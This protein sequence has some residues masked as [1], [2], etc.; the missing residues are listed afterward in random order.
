MAE[1]DP[2]QPKRD[3]ADAVAVVTGSSRGIGRGIAIALGERGATVYI[4][5]RTTGD[6]PLTIDSTAR[7]VD[8]A[9]GV[10]IAVQTDHTDDEQIA[11][12]F[13]R[14][15]EEQGRIDVLVNNVYKIPSPPVWGGGFWEHPYQVW[16]DQVGTGARCHYV[17]SWHAAPLL[18]EG[19]GKLIVNISSPGGLGYHYSSS[20]G[21]GKAALDRMTADF[22]VELQPKNVAAVSIYPGGVA[23]EF[24]VEANSERGR[25]LS[26]FQT[27]LFVG[28]SVA[29]LC[30]ADDLQDRSGK[31]LWVEDLAEEF[32]VVDEHGRRPPGYARRA[33]LTGSESPGG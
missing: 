14:I 21:V 23:T 32:D 30:T 1:N 7:A 4:T 10:G 17:A 15:A 8:G 3:L 28:R 33:E 26:D 13:E 11:A 22:A 24:V 12:L 25:D 20:Y 29:A 5:G 9:G 18:F 19:H 6:G 2:K 31:I 27:P 16:D